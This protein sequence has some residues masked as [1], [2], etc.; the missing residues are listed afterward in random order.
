MVIGLSSSRNK[1]EK[2]GQQVSQVFNKKAQDHYP[3]FSI[4]EAVMKCREFRLQS[5]ARL[6][7]T[8]LLPSCIAKALTESF[9]VLGPQDAPVSGTHSVRGPVC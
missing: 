5:T 4:P 1:G 9:D 2:T 3:G 7:P 8:A 6:G